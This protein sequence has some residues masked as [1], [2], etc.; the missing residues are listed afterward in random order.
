[1]STRAFGNHEERSR[2]LKNIEACLQHGKPVEAMAR[3]QD[4]LDRIRGADPE[5]MHLARTTRADQ[6][7]LAGWERLESRITH[8]E[9]KFGKR[10][11]A[12]GFDLSSPVHFG[13]EPE[14]DGSMECDIE[15][16]YYADLPNLAFSSADRA[17]I[18]RAAGV[19]EMAWKG[20]FVEVETLVAI[21]G[22][23][24]LYGAAWRN[25]TRRRTESV[26]A[27]AYELAAACCAVLFHQTVLGM[28]ER[29]AVPRNLTVL[30]GSNENFPMF[31]APVWIRNEG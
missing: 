27:D 9:A 5:M 31:D 22:M 2:Y 14:E 24:P 30:A 29:K 4:A 21:K 19:G 18:L 3:V 17:T 13:L 12:I 28:V 8:Y 6:L 16:N 20:E 7:T 26:E 23:E 25:A 15:T 11:T 10:I 1:M